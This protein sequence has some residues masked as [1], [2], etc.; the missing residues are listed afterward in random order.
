MMRKT[1]IACFLSIVCLGNNIVEGQVLK[2]FGKKLERKIEERIERKADRQV[3]K[4]LDKADKKSDESIND[5]LTKS[6]ADSKDSKKAKASTTFEPIAARPDQAVMLLGNN[7]HDFSWF[8]KGTMLGYESRDAKGKVEGAIDMKVMNLKNEGTKTIAQIEATLSSPHFESLIYPMNYICDGEMLYMD[9]ASMMKAMMEKNPEMDNKVVR[10]AFDKMEIDFSDGFA[11]FPKTMYP[12][13][14]LD[15]LNFSFK[16][17]VGAN[18][19]AFKTTVSDRQVVSKEKVTTPA[20]TFDCL[21]LRSIIR[22][23]LNVMGMNQNM[24]ESIEY[25]WIAPKVGM[26]KQET[27]AGKEINS[28]QLKV[29]K[30]AL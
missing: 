22:T 8:K 30:T 7:C 16:T 10:D 3:D 14:L 2:G 5:A 4:A 20:G 11:S 24:P 17:Q 15:D 21:K 12:G 23:S 27:H 19:M 18:E 13:M 29:Y 25:L 1:F 28:M 6:K 9:I 26:V